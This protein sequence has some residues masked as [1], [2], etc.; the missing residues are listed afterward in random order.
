MDTTAVNDLI[1][2]G[3]IDDAIAHCTQALAELPPDQH[4]QLHKTL[5]LACWYGQR[6]AEA[7]GWFQKAAAGSEVP[8]DWFN[9]AMTQVKVGDVEG[10]HAS[11]Q[12]TFD[13][14]YAHQDAPETSTFFDKKLLFA[15]ALRD[16][17]A[18]DARGLDLLE[19]QLLPFFTNYHVTDASFWGLRGV[20][21]MEDVLDTT[22]DYYRAMGKT[23]A[24][25]DALLTRIAP[26]LDDEGKATCEELRATWT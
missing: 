15:R 26:D 4:P 18:C 2:A 21:S 16:A 1:R 11:W 17:G 24:D 19:R 10:A 14:S 22:R 5:G 25:W 6:W 8:E 9:V 12:R 3:R 20:P 13:L 23:K 7:L